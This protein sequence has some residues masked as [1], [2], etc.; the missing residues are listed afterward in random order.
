MVYDELMK[1]N[2][3]LVQEWCQHHNGTKVQVQVDP[4]DKPQWR[5]MK[6]AFQMVQI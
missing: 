3:N 5:A 4:L 2:Y 1:K 6:Q